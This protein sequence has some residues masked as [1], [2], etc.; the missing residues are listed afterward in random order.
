MMKTGFIGFALLLMVLSMPAALNAQT[1]SPGCGNGTICT[2]TNVAET[3]TGCVIAEDEGTVE[4]IVV[5]GT[6][7]G[8]S[9]RS[10]AE[11]VD[12]I[13]VPLFNDGIIPLLYAL[14]FLFFL[15]GVVRYF[16]MGSEENREK[17][18]GMMLWGIIGLAV[19][20]SVWGL[21]SLLLSTFSLNSA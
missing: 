3:Q 13:I 2:Y 8:S 12:E 6:A 9:G 20:F 4:E 7:G 21:V 14:A 11:F 16:F 10:F 5:E 1:C 17:G 18:K 19:I 15:V